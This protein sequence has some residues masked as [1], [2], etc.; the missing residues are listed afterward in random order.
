M[1]IILIAVVV[2]A[3]IICFMVGAKVGQKVARGEE[4]KFPT[5]AP[6]AAYCQYRERKETQ[7]Q[8]ER[9]ATIL[10]NIDT[11]DGTETG[12]KDV[13]GGGSEWT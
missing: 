3:N 2:A 10:Q 9:M 8:Q 13:P 11:Y 6:M 12:Q 7:A 5:V 1:E 4:V